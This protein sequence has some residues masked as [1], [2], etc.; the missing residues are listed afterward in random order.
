MTIILVLLSKWY[1]AEVNGRKKT[2]HNTTQSVS[3]TTMRFGL[4]NAE[5]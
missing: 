1:R 2:Q 3:E 5:E 4:G